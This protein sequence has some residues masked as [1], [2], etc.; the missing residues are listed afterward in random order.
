V[1]DGVHYLAYRSRRPVDDGRG[2][3]VIVARL[4]SDGSL[5]E[6]CRI[7]KAAM[8]AESLERPAPRRGWAGSWRLYLSCATTGTRHWRVEMLRAPAP[9]AFVTAAAAW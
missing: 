5:T 3:D 9:D 6:L 4:G 7:D 2:G 1:L 8:D